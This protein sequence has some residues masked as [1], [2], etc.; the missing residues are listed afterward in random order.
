MQNQKKTP[1]ALFT[2]SSSI[3]IKRA[4]GAKILRILGDFTE[5]DP[6]L[7]PFSNKG[8]FFIGIP[9]MR[10]VLSIVRAEAL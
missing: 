5:K 9:L 4:E 10:P 6:L 2:R 7:C 3:I 1:A 8:V